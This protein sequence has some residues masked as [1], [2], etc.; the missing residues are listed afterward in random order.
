LLLLGDDLAVAIAW[1]PIHRPV[2]LRVA[3]GRGP[4]ATQLLG[5]AR[6]RAI[7]VHRDAQLARLLASD[8]PV[9]EP[10]WPR[11]AEIVAAVRG[12]GLP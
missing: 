12:R 7:P 2:P 10:H 5:L 11:I 4:G 6:R 1:D 3:T 9:P 8:G